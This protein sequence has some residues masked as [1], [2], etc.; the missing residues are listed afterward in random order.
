[1][2]HLLFWGVIAF[3]IYLVFQ[4]WNTPSNRAELK[5]DVHRAEQKIT[6]KV[7]HG[8]GEGLDKAKEFLPNKK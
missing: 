7:I 6:D 8:A 5:Q 3:I 4:G 2:H 1:M